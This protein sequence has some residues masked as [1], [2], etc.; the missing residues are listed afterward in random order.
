[1]NTQSYGLADIP[2][3]FDDSHVRIKFLA[4]IVTINTRYIVHAKINRILWGQM[5]VVVRPTVIFSDVVDH[6]Y[7][8]LR[9]QA[10]QLV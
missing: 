3:H 9:S 8:K 5:R 1:V 4:E 2:S 6:V 10:R 7:T